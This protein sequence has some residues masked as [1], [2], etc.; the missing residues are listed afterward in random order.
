MDRGPGTGSTGQWTE[1]QVRGVQVN[2]QKTRYG[3]YISTDSKPGTGSTG[4]WTEDQVR[5]VQVNGQK[6]RY[7]E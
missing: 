5:G 7:R 4:Q 6:T 1:D 3:E 2:G